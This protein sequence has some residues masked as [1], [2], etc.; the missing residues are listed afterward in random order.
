[1]LL[2]MDAMTAFHC[3]ADSFAESYVMNRM[4]AEERNQFTIHLKRCALCRLQVARTRSYIRAIRAA[5]AEAGGADPK[6]R[7]A[8]QAVSL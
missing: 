2:D 7:Q 5:F 8:V 3:D 4:P 1:M 6:A